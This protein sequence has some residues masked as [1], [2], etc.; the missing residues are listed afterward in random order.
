MEPGV[1]TVFKVSVMMMYLN[2]MYIMN[3]FELL[4]YHESTL[5]LMTMICLVITTVNI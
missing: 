3:C 4:K 1:N 5:L 2:L